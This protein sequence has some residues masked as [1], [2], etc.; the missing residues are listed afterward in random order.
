MT[1]N[2]P[3]SL[4]VSVIYF[5]TQKVTVTFVVGL[6]L[7]MIPKGHR[8]ISGR[9]DLL[10]KPKGHDGLCGRFDLVYEPKKSRGH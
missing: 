1:P 5:M 9:R 4:K 2:G 10:Y 6:T 7:F 3:R 8:V